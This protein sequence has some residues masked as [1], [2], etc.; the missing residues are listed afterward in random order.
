[1]LGAIGLSA[2]TALILGASFVDSGLAWTASAV[3]LAAALLVYFTMAGSLTSRLVLAFVQATLVELHIQLAR[4][5]TEFHFGVFVTLALLLVYLDWRPIL[6]AAVSIAVH[7]VVFDRLQAAGYGF[8]CLSQ[9][10]FALVLLHAAYVV[11][12]TGLE[13]VM[14]IQLGRLMQQG[15]ELDQIVGAV[16]QAEGIALGQAVTFD[17][18]TPTGKVLKSTLVRMQEAMLQ[19]NRSAEN[20]VAA[21]AQIAAGNAD[22]SARTENQASALEET[23]ASMEELGST[24]QQNADNARQANQLAQSASAVA[25]EGGEVVAQVVETM[26]G[27]HGSSQKS[28]TSSA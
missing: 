15:I 24:V 10:N 12:Q 27:I 11:I 7:H 3:L 6:L 19:V 26:K 13:L 8:Y 1:M 20:V 14:A 25:Q 28:P 18:H 16:N 5:M 23:A 17:A 22:L 9:P 2:V 21:S 4:G